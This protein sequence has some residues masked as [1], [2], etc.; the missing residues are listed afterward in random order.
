MCTG[1]HFIIFTMHYQHFCCLHVTVTTLRM[2]SIM[3]FRMYSKHTVSSEQ[4]LEFCKESQMLRE[5]LVHS[6]KH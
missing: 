1:L 2:Y 4:L 6:D 3:A 5:Q